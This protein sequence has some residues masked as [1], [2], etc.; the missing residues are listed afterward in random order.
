VLKRQDS[1][2]FFPGANNLSTT[3]GKELLISNYGMNLVPKTEPGYDDLKKS[4]SM[5]GQN[6]LNLAGQAAKNL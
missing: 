5:T 4:I 1:K 6:L 2:V 3:H